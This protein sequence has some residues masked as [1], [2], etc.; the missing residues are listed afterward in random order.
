MMKKACARLIEYSMTVMN[1]KRIYL[2][3]LQ[4]NER[5]IRLYEKLGF[6]IVPS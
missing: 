6:S 3:V 4:S 2:E 5:A 1:L